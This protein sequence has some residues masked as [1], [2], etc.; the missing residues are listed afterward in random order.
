MI[1]CN[2]REVHPEEL[3]F[4][5]FLI[6][7]ITLITQTECLC[8]FSSVQQYFFMQPNKQS[9]GKYANI[10]PFI[11]FIPD[12]TS[13]HFYCAGCKLVSQSSK[14]P[15][16]FS[17]ELW[18]SA[19]SIRLLFSPNYACSYLVIINIDSQTYVFPMVYMSSMFFNYFSA[20]IFSGLVIKSPFKLVHVPL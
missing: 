18:H 11:N 1:S 2:V 12:L 19:I 6:G 13:I 17:S 7:T 15:F 4:H 8:D 3:N 16:I 9:R 10:M 14:T 5:L 20:Q